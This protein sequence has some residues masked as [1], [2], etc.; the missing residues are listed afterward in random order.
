MAFYIPFYLPLPLHFYYPSTHT[1]HCGITSAPH[2]LYIDYFRSSHCQIFGQHYL[3]ALLENRIKYLKNTSRA[4]PFTLFHPDGM[5]R[6]FPVVAIFILHL[7]SVSLVTVFACYP[8]PFLHL[9]SI[10]IL[11]SFS[12]SL[13][14]E[15]RLIK[16]KLAK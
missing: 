15:Q 4:F 11:I 13:Y 8:Y 3:C 7:F 9:S 5:L 6:F 16:L 10:A 14:F 12:L 1:Q 2:L